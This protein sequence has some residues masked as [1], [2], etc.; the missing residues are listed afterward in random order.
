MHRERIFPGLRAQNICAI[1]KIPVESVVKVIVADEKKITIEAVVDAVKW[2]Y[3][4]STDEFRRDFRGMKFFAG[5]ETEEPSSL[6]IKVKED[7]AAQNTKPH[8][9]DYLYT[10][11][12]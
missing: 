5:A 7:V 8:A 1:G 9:K 12:L 6:T 4:L 3:F 2:K 11:V 10:S